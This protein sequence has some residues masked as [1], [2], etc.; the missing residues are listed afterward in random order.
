[1][2]VM[3]LSFSGPG[4]GLMVRLEDR[5]VFL[6][7]EFMFIMETDFLGEEDMLEM[8]VT[9]V[10]MFA[11]GELIRLR[12]VSEVREVRLLIRSEVSRGSMSMSLSLSSPRASSMWAP[13]SARESAPP[14]AL[15]QVTLANKV[16]LREG[17]SIILHGGEGFHINKVTLRRSV[18]LTAL[19]RHGRRG[20]GILFVLTVKVGGVAVIILH[21]PASLQSLKC[22]GIHHS[23]LDCLGI[24]P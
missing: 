21:H 19:G 23:L 20:A 16:E 8:M 22:V 6:G 3:K 17:S 14:I 18:T 5:R 15:K 13:E 2:I 10:R 7:E 4:E 24:L 11:T 9:G 1:L 12:G